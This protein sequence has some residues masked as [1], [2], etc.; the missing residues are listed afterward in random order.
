MP[1]FLFKYIYITASTKILSVFYNTSPH[2]WISPLSQ[3]LKWGVCNGNT[4]FLFLLTAVVDFWF[5]IVCPC[6][7][8]SFWGQRSWMLERKPFP[9]CSHDRQ[10]EV[11]DDFFS[12]LQCMKTVLKH[13]KNESRRGMD[14]VCNLKMLIS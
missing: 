12:S 5:N 4:I 11:T 14:R 3:R 6:P 8:W 13:C 7:S 10:R 1:E 9:P 2:A